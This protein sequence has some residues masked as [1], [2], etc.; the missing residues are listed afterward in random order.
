MLLAVPAV[1]K[2]PG[3]FPATTWLLEEGFDPAENGAVIESFASYLMLAF[4]NWAERGFAAV[5]D[6]YLAR[7]GD[8]DDGAPCG[9]DSN[10]DLLRQRAAG[11]ERVP[12]LPALPAAGWYDPSTGGPRLS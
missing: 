9:I 3:A 10:G 4:D 6:R 11:I 7:L 2:D 8:E 12:L 1:E 5:A